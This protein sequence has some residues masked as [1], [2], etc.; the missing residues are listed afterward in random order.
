MT[1]QECTE[2]LPLHLLG[3]L[4]PAE[5]EEVRAHLDN[6]PSCTTEAAEEESTAALIALSL[7]P[8]AP[9]KEAR[10]RLMAAIGAS[11]R[12]ASEIGASTGGASTSDGN[13]AAPKLAGQN[14]ASRWSGLLSRGFGLAALIALAIMLFVANRQRERIATLDRALAQRD[15]QMRAQARELEHGQLSR[16]IQLTGAGP[17][18]KATGHVVLEKDTGR[19]HVCVFDLQPPPP[20]RSY[21]VWFTTESGRRIFAGTVVIGQEGAGHAPMALP[22]EVNEPILLAAVTDE[23]TGSSG[24]S[25]SGQ[26]HLLGGVK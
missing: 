14:A 2:Q 5:N 13:R 17:H 19:W 18:P 9:S 23:P 21:G 26:A 15:A 20:G 7:P 8:I 6:C 16:V 22:P 1:C 12:G 11:A 4:S 24:P 10:E 25:P 3:E